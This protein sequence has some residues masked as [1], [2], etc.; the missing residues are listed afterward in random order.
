MPGRGVDGPLAEASVGMEAAGGLDGARRPTH[1][2]VWH[3]AACGQD[4]RG[5]PW[6]PCAEPHR[7]GHNTVE[8]PCHAVPH[9][10]PHR[11][12]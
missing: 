4:G 7:S 6:L 1:I 2:H 5:A 10:V 12:P 9:D 11:T 3:V 8:S